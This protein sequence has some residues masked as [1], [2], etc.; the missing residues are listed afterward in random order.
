MPRTLR[1]RLVEDGSACDGKSAALE[2]NGEGYGR[3]R[4]SPQG[5]AFCDA[6]DGRTQNKASVLHM[7]CFATLVGRVR[8][9]TMYVLS[10]HRSTRN[11]RTAHS[12]DAPHLLAARTALIC[13]AVTSLP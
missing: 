5:E 3:P 1:S 13:S 9:R 7:A 12:L 11:V 8:A 6:Q 10:W 4:A 2:S